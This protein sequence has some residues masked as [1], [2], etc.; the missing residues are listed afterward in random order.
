MGGKNKWNAG[1]HICIRAFRVE[2]DLGGQDRWKAEDWRTAK[3][4]GKHAKGSSISRG[5][6]RW[7]VILE[8]SNQPQVHT[9]DAPGR[10]R[11][12]QPGSADTRGPMKGE[13]WDFH[14]RGRTTQATCRQSLSFV[15][16]LL[17]DADGN[18]HGGENINR[19]E[20]S[21]CRFHMLRGLRVSLFHLAHHDFFYP[22]FLY[23]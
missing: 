4:R 19:E 1:C 14:F 22:F 18:G 2:E 12:Q 23:I 11:S 15:K 16:I 10:S 13:D 6:S 8:Y 9:C 3:S 17:K 5:C 7:V 21:T 20:Y